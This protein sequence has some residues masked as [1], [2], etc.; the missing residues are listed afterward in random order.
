MDKMLLQKTAQLPLK[1]DQPDQTYAED[2]TNKIQQSKLKC[3]LA[4]QKSVCIN[5]NGKHP[6]SKTEKQAIIQ[7][8]NSQQ[9]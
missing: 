5:S 8:R 7:I 6:V 1:R 3:T 2:E 9:F 4:R